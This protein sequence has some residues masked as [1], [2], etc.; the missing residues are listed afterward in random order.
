MISATLAHL[1]RI[2]VVFTILKLFGPVP[3]MAVFSRNPADGAST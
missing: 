2:Y 3:N 1:K